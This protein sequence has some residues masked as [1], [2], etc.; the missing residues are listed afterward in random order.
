MAGVS[1]TDIY[2]AALKAANRIVAANP[3]LQRSIRLRRQKNSDAVLAGVVSKNEFFY[4]VMCNPPF[5]ASAAQAADDSQRKACNLKLESNTLRNFGGQHNELWCEG[6]EKAFVGHMIAE[7][8]ALARQEIEQVPGVEQ[9]QRGEHGD[10]ACQLENR[11][12]PVVD[13]LL[14]RGIVAAQIGRQRNGF[15]DPA[16]QDAGDEGG[17]TDNRQ[18]AHRGGHH[19]FQAVAGIEYRQQKQGDEVGAGQPVPHQREGANKEGE[20]GHAAIGERLQGAVNAGRLEK[21]SAGAQTV[22]MPIISTLTSAETGTLTWL[23]TIGTITSRP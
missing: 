17:D 18:H 22:M 2:E 3:G 11:L 4:A 5:H 21:I 10:H 1:S 19:K 12:D 7:S 13:P 14:Q 20:E 15:A 6:G 9:H 23:E 16:R 8:A